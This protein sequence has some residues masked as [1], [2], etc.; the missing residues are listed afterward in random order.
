MEQMMERLLARMEA[1]PEKT[2]DNLGRP[3]ARMKGHI[4]AN[5]EDTKA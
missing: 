2:D 1:N 4:E 3:E 5:K